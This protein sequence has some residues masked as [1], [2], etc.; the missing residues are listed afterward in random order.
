MLQKVTEMKYN[1]HNIM[2]HAWK[3]VKCYG[4]DLSKALK[5]AWRAAKEAGQT[6]A[7]TIV[8]ETEKAVGFQ[9]LVSDTNCAIGGCFVPERTL[10][11][12][13]SLLVDGQAPLW[14]VR[15]KI[16]ELARKLYVKADDIILA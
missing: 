11:A 6:V 16:N 8:K 14:L 1:L 9:V 4:Y 5:R 7:L 3:L 15:K 10:W 12:P 2:T 13:K